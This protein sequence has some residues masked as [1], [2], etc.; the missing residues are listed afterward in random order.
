MAGAGEAVQIGPAAAPRRYHV[1]VLHTLACLV[2]KD[3][4]AVFGVHTVGF[5]PALQAPYRVANAG[6]VGSNT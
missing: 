3:A 1:A 5:C 4:L 6:N 2:N